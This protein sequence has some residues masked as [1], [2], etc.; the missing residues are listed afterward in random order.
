MDLDLHRAEPECASCL[1][2]G[3]IA[4]AD[5]DG[6]GPELGERIAFR[7]ALWAER[8]PEV[9]ALDQSALLQQGPDEALGGAGCH[10]FEDAA[11]WPACSW[12]A[13]DAQTASR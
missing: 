7:E 13:R 4:A 1:G 5:D 8:Q 2:A 6:Y 3:V 12:G 11:S 10:R 9:P